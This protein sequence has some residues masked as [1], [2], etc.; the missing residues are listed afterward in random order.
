METFVAAA[1]ATAAPLYLSYPKNGLLYQAG[2]D[3]VAILKRHYKRAE[4]LASVSLNHSTM[5]AAPGTAS[6]EVMEDVY[7]AH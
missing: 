7:Y 6:I 4:I 2:A 1:A 5:G 3:P